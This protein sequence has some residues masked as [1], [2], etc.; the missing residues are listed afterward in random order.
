MRIWRLC[1]G[2]WGRG[3]LRQ[4]D[5]LEAGQQG[6]Q[7]LVRVLLLVA[8]EERAEPADG[9]Q[10]GGGE[11]WLARFRTIL[12]V[13]A[14]EL[15]EEVVQGLDHVQQ[16]LLLGVPVRLAVSQV[17]VQVV[18]AV[19]EARGEPQCVQHRVE[20][21]GVA[22][23]GEG[24]DPRAVGA[25]FISVNPVH[26]PAG[27]VRSGGQGR[28]PLL[29]ILAVRLLVG[30]GVLQGL[31]HHLR[32]AALCILRV[33]ILNQARQLS[34]AGLEHSTL[35]PPAQDQKLSTGGQANI[36][37]QNSGTKFCKIAF[38]QHIFIRSMF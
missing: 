12:A 25:P 5:I 27:L 33:W 19:A 15:L 34:R 10:Q 13:G 38:Y 9:M 22:Q 30:P 3:D 18:E 31:R 21:A 7:Q 36:Q 11:D 17:V 35:Q 23:V 26:H 20:E 6:D 1:K 29:P 4:L 8:F 16:A 37:R 32:V 14:A 28:N 2:G 24:R